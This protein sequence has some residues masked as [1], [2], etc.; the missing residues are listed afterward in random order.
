MYLLNPA[1]AKTI[2]VQKSIKVI[3]H[4]KLTTQ[5]PCQPIML[6]YAQGVSESNPPII[7][8]IVEGNF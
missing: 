3:Q 5:K 7:E 4:A 2:N 6:L 1:I 8:N